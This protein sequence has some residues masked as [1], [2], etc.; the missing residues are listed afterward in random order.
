MGEA[1]QAMVNNEDDIKAHM[2]G[3]LVRYRGRLTGQFD[4][5]FPREKL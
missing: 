3:A 2:A 1:F 5:L 4:G